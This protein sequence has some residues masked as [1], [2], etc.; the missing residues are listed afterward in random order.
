M[1]DRE[2]S[3]S[4][5]RPAWIPWAMTS[6]VLL[7]VAFGAFAFG[8]R[9]EA[10]GMVGEPVVRHWHSSFPGFFFGM[11]LLFFVLSGFRR[12][13]WWG[14]FPYYRPWRYRRYFGDDPREEE[15]RWEEWHRREH[16]R[17]DASRN[18]PRT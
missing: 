10:D 6:F 15:R 9:W 13:W 12:M 1:D 16:E 18:N 3:E 4:Y 14:G 2:R 5:R 11:F 7:L 8:T 17:M